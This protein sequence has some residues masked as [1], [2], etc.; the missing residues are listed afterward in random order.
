MLYTHMAAWIYHMLLLESDLSK[1]TKSSFSEVECDRCI[2]WLR[3]Q[4]SWFLYFAFELCFRLT[5]VNYHLV[6]S[7]PETQV[8]V[9]GSSL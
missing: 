1:P 9:I 8:P 6:L 5:M 4:C 3:Y 2:Q 7:S